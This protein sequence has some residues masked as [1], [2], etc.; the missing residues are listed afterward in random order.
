M[1]HPGSCKSYPGYVCQKHILDSIQD[2][3]PL[4]SVLTTQEES[5]G[6]YSPC[7]SSASPKVW[8]KRMTSPPLLSISTRLQDKS[9]DNQQDSEAEDEEEED[10]TQLNSQEEPE[11]SPPPRKRRLLQ[12]RGW[13]LS[14]TSF[15][16]CHLQNERTLSWKM[17]CQ[18]RLHI[19]C[20]S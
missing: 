11:D 20:G 13:A 18:G 8:F 12:K 5:S 16:L 14:M 17:E 1:S 19:C 7:N 9:P 15:L 3:C 4:I 2:L 10:I 6:R